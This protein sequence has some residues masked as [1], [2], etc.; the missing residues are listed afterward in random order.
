[1]DGADCGFGRIYPILSG[2]NL[3]GYGPLNGISQLDLSKCP[4]TSKK[5]KRH[6]PVLRSPSPRRRTNLLNK[7]QGIITFNE[8]YDTA[9][10]AASSYNKGNGFP[11]MTSVLQQAYSDAVTLAEMAQNVDIS[12][13]GFTHYFGGAGVALQHTHFVTTMGSITSSQNRYTIEFD[14]AKNSLCKGQIVFFIDASPGTSTDKKMITACSEFWTS[15]ASRYLLGSN[16]KTTPSPPYR[17]R[18][19]DDRR[20]WCTKTTVKNDPNVSDRLNQYFATAGHSVLHELTHLDALAEAAGL[21]ANPDDNTHGT[22]DDQKHCELK[23]AR[24]WLKTYMGKAGNPSP[25]YNA[26]SYAAAAT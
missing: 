22:D 26:E 25:D 10:P 9:P 20:G 8:N 13:L 15:A 4:A 23:D 21:D 7:R 16:T 5:A 12:D 19:V 1:M 14:C 18:D 11:T 24:A 2:S 3:Y 17:S 6:E